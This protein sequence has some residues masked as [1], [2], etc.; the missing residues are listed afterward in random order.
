[1]ARK[2]QQKPT[3][4]Q[5]LQRTIV[6]E[7]PTEKAFLSHLRQ[8][9]NHEKIKI[10]IKT[11]HGKGPNNIIGDAIGTYNAT[12]KN[13]QVAAL[14]D[15]DLDW[16]KSQVKDCDKCGIKLVGIN[17][18]IEALMIE[19]LGLKLPHPAT[20]ESCKSLMQPKL[21]GSSTDKRSYEKLFTEEVINKALET[22]EK[23]REVKSLFQP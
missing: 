13:M 9:F 5:R 11:A 23:L 1:M 15:L 7:G 10:T 17:P 22:S 16:D 14:L 18:C 8:F 20:N 12:A 6:G 19:I 3:R 4:H 21:S 2:K